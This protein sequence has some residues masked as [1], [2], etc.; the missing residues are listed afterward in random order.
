MRAADMYA[1]VVL[2]ACVAYL[3]NLAF[4]AWEARMIGWA[5]LRENTGGPR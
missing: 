4:M 3:L 1:A 5:R 2:L